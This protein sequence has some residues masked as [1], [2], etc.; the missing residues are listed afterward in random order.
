M[1]V[2]ETDLIVTWEEPLLGV[3][4][5]SVIGYN[6]VCST[7]TMP[8][9]NIEYKAR[10]VVQNTTTSIVIPTLDNLQSN[11]AYNCCVEVEYET[12]SSIACVSARYYCRKLCLVFFWVF[13]F[14]LCC[15][16]HRS[17]QV[18]TTTLSES[19]TITISEQ[20]TTTSRTSIVIIGGVLGAIIAILTLSLVLSLAG[21]LCMYRRVKIA[22][23]DR[24]IIERVKS[25]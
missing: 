6:I 19:S 11:V 7:S 10:V 15:S 12:Y 20:L 24:E 9:S 16:S 22:E 3:T 1:N 17:V 25:R 5:D 18:T 14:K 13:F 4:N 21:L 2:S 8:D 23:D